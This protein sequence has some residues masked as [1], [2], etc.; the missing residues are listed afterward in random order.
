MVYDKL[1]LATGGL[2]REAK[3]VKGIQGA[4][5]VYNLRDAGDQE[6]IKEKAKSVKDGIAILGSSFIGSEAAASLKMKYKDAFDVHMIGLEEYP[7]ETVFGKEIGKMMAN[8]HT[9]NGVKLH[10]QKDIKEII[11]NSDGEIEAMILNDGSKHNVSML[12]CGVG[13]QP[14]T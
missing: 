1:L 12:I 3:W 4:K 14:K 10:M 5:N 9:K 11:K 7:I 8:E 13:I 2:P 6:K